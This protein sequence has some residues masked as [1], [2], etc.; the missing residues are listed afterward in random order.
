VNVA[1]S[2]AVTLAMLVSGSAAGGTD[3]VP[4]TEKT[5]ATVGI[6]LDSFRVDVGRY[7][8]TAEGLAALRARPAGVPAW[9]DG[10]RF[11]WDGPYLERERDL[12]DPRGRAFGY[13]SPAA[14]G[15]SYELWV[16][17]GTE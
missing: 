8:T 11:G 5:D 9:R 16:V 13:R 2:F 4:C 14:D 15:R 10:Q 7:P 3:S 6:A 12:R 1:L 17:E